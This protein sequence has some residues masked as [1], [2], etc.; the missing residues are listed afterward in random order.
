MAIEIDDLITPDRIV[1]N[2]DARSRKRALELLAEALSHSTTSHLG[3]AEAFAS[4]IGRERLG[5][6]GVGHGVAIPHGR[7]AGLDII[8]GAFVQ[9]AEPVDFEA[10]D[11]RPVDLLFGL[12]V[13]EHCTDEHLDTLAALAEMFSDDDFCTALRQAGSRERIYHLLV[14]GD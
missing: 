5:T 3:Q 4:I 13:P 9:L 1:S 12:L 14:E 11:E 2:G 6:T 7:L 8:I 10:P